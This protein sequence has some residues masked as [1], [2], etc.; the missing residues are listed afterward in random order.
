MCQCIICD[1]IWANLCG[2]VFG[3]FY[4]GCMCASCW[5]CMPDEMLQI[6]PECV[7]IGC[8]A[9]WGYN[10]CCWGCVYCIPDSIRTYSGVKTMGADVVGVN[11][12]NTGTPL[13]NQQGYY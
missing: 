2:V 12:G 11:G 6:D 10:Y 1:C 4:H 13:N 7:K 9:G 8:C 5:L 3:G